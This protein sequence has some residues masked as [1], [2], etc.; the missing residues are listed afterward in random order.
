MPIFPLYDQLCKVQESSLPDWPRLCVAITGL[1]LGHSKIIYALILHHYITIQGN[2]NMSESQGS[3]ARFQ[4]A[5]TGRKKNSQLPYGGKTFDQGKGI[6]F[7]VNNVPLEL[8]NVIS[9]YLTYISQ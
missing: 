8:R 7:N 2:T 9:A 6:M 3:L 4:G 1:S 5:H